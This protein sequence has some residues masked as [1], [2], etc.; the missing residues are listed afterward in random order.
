MWNMS[1]PSLSTTPLTNTDTSKPLP[2]FCS[3]FTDLDTGS[4][5]NSELIN[6]TQRSFTSTSQTRSSLPAG[7]QPGTNKKVFTTAHH[8]RG[9]SEFV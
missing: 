2:P 6:P 7:L 8:V 5:S 9:D 4:A 3:N 1:N